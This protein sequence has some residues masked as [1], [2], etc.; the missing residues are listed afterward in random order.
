MPRSWSLSVRG[1][2]TPRPPRS[3]HSSLSF[4]C[5]VA[6]LLL[7]TSIALGQVPPGIVTQRVRPADSLRDAK[8]ATSPALVPLP[9]DALKVDAPSSTPC[10]ATNTSTLSEIKG[11]L[12]GTYQVQGKLDSTTALAFPN[13]PFHNSTLDQWLNAHNAALL[14]TLNTRLTQG[15]RGDFQNLEQRACSAHGVY[16][17]IAYRQQA[18][19][20]LL[21]PK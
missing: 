20:L 10:P 18:I 6:L 8:T 21:V 7:D 14:D 9:P 13:P 4:Y 3:R 15:E 19:R 11:R 16:C 1:P 2:R 12:N 5:V 17:T